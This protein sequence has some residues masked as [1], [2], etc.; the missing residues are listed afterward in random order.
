MKDFVKGCISF[1]VKDLLEA[2]A[3][4]DGS[5]VLAYDV[6]MACLKHKTE[7]ER[8]QAVTSVL[9]NGMFRTLS[10]PWEA[11]DGNYE[12]QCFARDLYNLLQ[13]YEWPCLR[14]DTKSIL[15]LFEHNMGVAI[16]DANN[17]LRASM[18]QAFTDYT[19]NLDG[20]QLFSKYLKLSAA[21]S[22]LLSAYL[23]GDKTQVL[24]AGAILLCTASELIYSEDEAEGEAAHELWLTCTNIL[25]VLV[26]WY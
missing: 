7:H 12:I 14:P 3:E 24:A 4:A 19:L 9:L 26:K 6:A 11:D 5:M 20:E 8:E 22:N 15:R 18:L 10:S 1:S 13:E 17:T 16:T 21:K 2:T 25:E 23:C